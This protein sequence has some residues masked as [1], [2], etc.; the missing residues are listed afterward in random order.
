MGERTT[1]VNRR[2]AVSDTDTSAV[3]LHILREDGVGGL[4]VLGARVLEKSKKVAKTPR[5]SQSGERE[6][7]LGGGCWIKNG[8]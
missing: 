8:V 5:G 6:T 4:R 7:G 1:G 2:T 3:L